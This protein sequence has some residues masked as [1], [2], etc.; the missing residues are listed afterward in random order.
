VRLVP[1]E[2]ADP[3]VV[4]SWFPSTRESATSQQ[5][6]SILRELA[7]LTP[8]GVREQQHQIRVLG[9][10]FSPRGSFLLVRVDRLQIKDQQQAPA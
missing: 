10:A 8:V 5:A 1:A 2:I 3:A 9:Y 4:G 6:F 7:A